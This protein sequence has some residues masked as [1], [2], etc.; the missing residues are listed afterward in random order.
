MSASDW[1]VCPRCVLR[2]QAK[3]SQALK[4]ADD[5]YGKVSAE[6][7]LAAREKLSD[8]ATIHTEDFDTFREDY[9][10]LGADKGVVKVT[11]SGNCEVCGLSLSFEEDHPIPGVSS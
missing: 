4:K 8:I 5:L 10:I 2:A 11:Y 1:S 9:E 3:R 7:F 6:E